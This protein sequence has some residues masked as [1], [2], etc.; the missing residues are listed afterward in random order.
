MDH[1]QQ[2][3]SDITIDPLAYQDID[4]D[5]YTYPYT[6]KLSDVIN[7]AAEVPADG[8][9]IYARAWVDGVDELYTVNNDSFMTVGGLLSKYQ[10]QILMDSALIEGENG[11]Y[12]VKADISNNSLQDTDIGEITADILDSNNN[13]LA[14]VPLN[15]E[16][17]TMAGENKR[18][19]T[20]KVPALSAKPASVSLRS[21]TQSITLDAMTNGGISDAVSVNLT[22]DKTIA[23]M[24]PEATA[25]GEPVAAAGDIR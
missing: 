23:G 10:S 18:K 2:I 14:S 16:N 20:A 15:Q 6:L 11:T 24:L 22:A 3:G 5:I 19:L 21:S 7:G 25:G 12:T 9:R 1:T 13:I 4:D 8:V 17:S